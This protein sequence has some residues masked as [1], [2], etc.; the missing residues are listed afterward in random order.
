EV[1]RTDRGQPRPVSQ[2]LEALSADSLIHQGE[3][4]ETATRGRR[5]ENI[6]AEHSITIPVLELVERQFA[7]RGKIRRMQETPKPLI[8]KEILA[9]TEILDVTKNRIVCHRGGAIVLEEVPTQVKHQ[10]V[11]EGFRLQQI[12]WW[13]V[14]RSSSPKD[15]P[16]PPSHIARHG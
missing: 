7:Q 14:T 1:E 2:H 4:V 10:Q 5:E 3:A 9:Q 13:G 12:Q 11:T 16:T 6:K 8:F 15:E